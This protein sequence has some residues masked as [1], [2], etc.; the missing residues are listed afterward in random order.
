[1]TQHPSYPSDADRLNTLLDALVSGK[2]VPDAGPASD[3]DAFAA[4][5]RLVSGDAAT[6]VSATPSED[7]LDDI[8]RTIMQIPAP[9]PAAMDKTRRPISARQKARLN[10][11]PEQSW[12]SR[13]QSLASIAA[14]A[15]MLIVLIGTAWFSSRG[16]GP[17]PP[18]SER[19][20]AQPLDQGTPATETSPSATAQLD[21]AGSLPAATYVHP[22]PAM[23][24]VEPLTVDEVMAMTTGEVATPTTSTPVP[25]PEMNEATY[26]ELRSVLDQHL[27]CGLAGDPFRV[28]AI[29]S[30]GMIRT[31]LTGIAGPWMP[32]AQLR[33]MLEEMRAEIDAAPENSGA[34]NW[35]PEGNPAIPTMP[36]EF[37]PA[38]A[39]IDEDGRARVTVVWVTRDGGSPSE[40][41]GYPVG[42]EDGVSE[43][44][45]FWDAV[46]GR[47]LIDGFATPG[48]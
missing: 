26:E 30:P 27:S 38:L 15:A 8:W 5:H 35:D 9:I 43:M 16:N 23:C 24:T 1:M 34:F 46:Q 22:N 20:A 12:R 31:Q 39:S 7:T 36:D 4:V 47:W 25:L 11:V 44:I 19:Y 17:E 42:A 3:P 21:E 28:W 6:D 10:A 18:G 48:E 37:D 32:E 14:I 29:S 33:Q 45:F 41:Y 40:E 2:R 13:F